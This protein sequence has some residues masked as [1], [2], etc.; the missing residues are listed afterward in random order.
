[1]S[2][3]RSLMIFY[4]KKPDVKEEQAKSFAIYMLQTLNNVNAHFAD[5]KINILTMS[6]NASDGYGDFINQVDFGAWFIDFFS[7]YPTFKIY[8]ISILEEKKFP[9]GIK[10]MP[11]N[12][13]AKGVLQITS[14]QDYP[15]TNPLEGPQNILC[16]FSVEPGK[17]YIVP[18][19]VPFINQLLGEADFVFNAARYFWVE[20]ATVG[21]FLRYFIPQAYVVSRGEYGPLGEKDKDSYQKKIYYENCMGPQDEQSGIK[22][23]PELMRLCIEAKTDSIKSAVLETLENKNLLKSILSGDQPNHYLKTHGFAFGYI[24]NKDY[25]VLFARLMIAKSQN[26]EAGV[27]IVSELSHFNDIEKNAL[28]MEQLKNNQYGKIIFIKN[29]GKEEKVIDVPNANGGKVLTLVEFRGTSQVDKNKMIALSDMVAGSGNSS[30]SEMISSLRFP[31]IQPIRHVIH[32]YNAFINELKTTQKEK[33]EELAN[34]FNLLIQPNLS[35][36]DIRKLISIMSDE[37]KLTEMSITWKNF[38]MYLAEKRNEY[39][40]FL[41]FTSAFIILKNLEIANKTPNLVQAALDDFFKFF[42][43]GKIADTTLLHLVIERKL[44][45]V[46]DFL[47]NVGKEFLNSPCLYKKFTPLMVAACYKNYDYVKALLNKNVSLYEQDSDGLTVIHQA[48]KSG[49]MELVKLL[50]SKNEDLILL[51]DKNGKTPLDY[52]IESE[53]KE[54]LEFLVPF[55]SSVNLE[56]VIDTLPLN[57]MYLFGICKGPDDLM[58]I[59]HYALKTNSLDLFSRCCRD[60]KVNTDEHFQADL[61][62]LASGSLDFAKIFLQTRK[63]AFDNV[64]FINNLPF[65]IKSFLRKDTN[66]YRDVDLVQFQLGMIKLINVF[67]KL[68]SPDGMGLNLLEINNSFFTNVENLLF[69]SKDS[70]KVKKIISDI[71]LQLCKF[72]LQG[73][74]TNP[75]YKNESESENRL[76]FIILK[77][78]LKEYADDYIA[79]NSPSSGSN[80][81]LSILERNKKPGLTNEAQAF[82]VLLE[83]CEDLNAINDLLYP[84]VSPADL[85]PFQL[86]LAEKLEKEAGINMSQFIRKR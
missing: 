21:K 17:Q 66:S 77:I 43:D 25:S 33:A 34:Y 32:F 73:I 1:M 16:G 6:H 18:L 23:Y 49:D 51:K 22:I 85:N 74:N 9:V 62:L 54:M 75:K 72:C 55:Y 64:A 40:D 86:F 42:P 65:L 28:F 24:Q 19:N 44:D 30:F 78:R 60:D 61:M 38:C 84:K 70:T 81:F 71:A 76:G 7:K 59:A 58:G 36:E 53:N 47:L 37:A 10:L 14:E 63:Q 68:L 3:E 69:A 82:L 20:E 57:M 26:K 80:V 29:D 46:F 5:H 15:K 45:V 52:A 48:V 39:D 2:I 83:E 12:V 35:E 79:L 50:Y 56:T 31:F 8:G 4:A 41:E 13:K 11:D 67:K 27:T